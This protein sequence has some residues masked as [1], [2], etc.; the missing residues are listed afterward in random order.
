MMSLEKYT[1]ERNENFEFDFVKPSQLNRVKKEIFNS[2]TL[3]LH[4]FQTQIK[5]L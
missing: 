5:R 1:T 3:L 4:G 2:K